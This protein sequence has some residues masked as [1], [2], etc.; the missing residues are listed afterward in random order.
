M[1][2]PSAS[3]HRRPSARGHPVLSGHGG[4][5]DALNFVLGRSAMPLW[6]HSNGS[7][8]GSQQGYQACEHMV[9]RVPRC[10]LA[11]QRQNGIVTYTIARFYQN[12]RPKCEWG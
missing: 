2:R 1:L 9:T 8:V 12:D 3:K 6:I 7:Y 5:D 10:G 4:L 11:G